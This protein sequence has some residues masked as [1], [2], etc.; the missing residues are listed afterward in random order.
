M[1]KTFLTVFALL[2][3][4]VQTEY[5]A[6][7]TTIRVPADYRSIQEA[8]D[9]AAPGDTV[10]VDDG[11]YA[12]NLLIKKT[13]GLRSTGGAKSTVIEA[14][15]KARPV[16]KISGASGVS[17]DGFTITGSGAS[18]ILLDNADN[19]GISNNRVVDNFNGII[20]SY[21][22]RNTI[23]KNVA[24]S[25]EQYGIYIERSDGNRVEDNTVS[26]NDDKGIY[27]TFSNENV[28]IGN[29]SYLNRWDGLLLWTSNNNIIKDNKV[30]RN[31]Y[32]IIITESVGN[33]VEGN[34]T[35]PNIIIILPV[36]LIYTGIL[37]YLLEKYLL[38]KILARQHA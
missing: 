36:L 4:L 7:A 13:L 16:V 3:L 25:N 21:S 12:E 30:L 9:T 20:L 34:S 8:I 28:L 10:Q 1:G 15:D 6:E 38:T 18:G 37:F 5:R 24:D 2:T 32:A 35:W 27:L 31:A 11:H 23:E 29:R 14:S 19:T 26:S 22:N 33:E 17:I